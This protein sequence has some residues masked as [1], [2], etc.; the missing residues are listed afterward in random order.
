MDKWIVGWMIGEGDLKSLAAVGW[1]YLQLEVAEHSHA[2]DPVH[3]VKNHQH[4]RVVRR[5]SQH[6]CD[7]SKG[8]NGQR[9][10]VVRRDLQKVN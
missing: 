4:L 2:E 8:T 1:T 9:H 3:E 6:G 7:G 10:S 5:S